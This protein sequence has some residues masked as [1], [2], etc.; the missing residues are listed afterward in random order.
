MDMDL[1]GSRT[2]GPLGLAEYWGPSLGSSRRCPDS[3]RHTHYCLGYGRGAIDDI[4]FN[5]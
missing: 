4:S 3:S 1:R 2:Q 5:V